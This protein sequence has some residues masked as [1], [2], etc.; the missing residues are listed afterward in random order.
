MFWREKEVRP[1]CP[2]STQSLKRLA[3]YDSLAFTNAV[4]EHA[5]GLVVLCRLDDFV[6]F[7]YFEFTAQMWSR[8]SQ[9]NWPGALQADENYW[10]ILVRSIFTF[11]V[12][13][14]FKERS[15]AL[16]GKEL[17]EGVVVCAV[18]LGWLISDLF[19]LI[20]SINMSNFIDAVKI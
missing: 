1:D 9:L 10:C 16:P 5:K 13:L 7:S 18:V 3:R 6:F 11:T 20:R 8:S 12:I 17:I 4:L 15:V 19:S 2:P 14:R